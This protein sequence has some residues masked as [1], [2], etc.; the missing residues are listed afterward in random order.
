[1]L[2]AGVRYPQSCTVHTHVPLVYVCVQTATLDFV[3]QTTPIL[4][5]PEGSLADGP[6]VPLLH[7][8]LVLFALTMH[9][10][11]LEKWD[12]ACCRLLLRLTGGR[13]AGGG[14]AQACRRVPLRPALSRCNSNTVAHSLLVAIVRSHL[15]QG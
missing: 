9:C 7:A 10:R 13:Q 1:M 4:W 3:I 12:F 15:F 6:G 11:Q 2:S 14:M 5:L 8:A